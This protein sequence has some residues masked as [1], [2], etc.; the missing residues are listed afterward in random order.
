MKYPYEKIVDKKIHRSLKKFVKNGKLSRISFVERDHDI[1]KRRKLIRRIHLDEENSSIW[2]YM[3]V[4]PGGKCIK[5]AA[6]MR[7]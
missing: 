7:D 5:H 2:R 1:P 6:V 3:W 4:T